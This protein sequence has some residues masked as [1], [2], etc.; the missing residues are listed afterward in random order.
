MTH[1]RWGMAMN[2]LGARATRL[3]GALMFALMAFAVAAPHAASQPAVSVERITVH[4]VSLEGN[5]EGNS[6]DR[7]VTV[8]LPPGYAR[9]GERR[10]PVI[11]G[12]HG[13]TINNDIWS[14]ELR[15]E[16][17]LNAAYAAGLRDLIVVLPSAQTRHN[18]SM[19]SSSVTVGDWE[20]FIAEDLVAYIDAHYRTLATR[21]SR[22]L[23]GHSMGGYGASRIGMKRPDVFSALY[24]MSPCCMSARDAPPADFLA[25]L[26]ALQTPEQ[27]AALGFMERA[28]LAVGAAWSPNPNKPPFYLDLPTGDDASRN[29]VLAQWA[30]NAPLA[31][32]EQNI[33]NLR[34]YS[35]IA[36]DVG[37][38]DGLRVDAEAFHNLLKDSNVA[39]TFEIYDGDHVSGVAQRFERHVAPFFDRA[40]RR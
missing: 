18:G 31:M 10:Y 1:A 36:I 2:L 15:A 14:Q 38:R 12:L 8:Y 26:E 4:G 24:I 29:S 35:A 13:Y 27:A 30:A 32:A 28:T 22:G 3:V 40:L 37:D 21:E 7:S 33:F 19:Y 20:R 6:A 23:F 25:R 17:S 11:Y 16:A 5:L 9:D 34:R 39:N